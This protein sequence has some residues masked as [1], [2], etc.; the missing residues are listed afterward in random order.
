[1]E[2]TIAIVILSFLL[3]LAIIVIYLMAR[4]IRQQEKD[5]E[6]Q[7]KMLKAHND[8]NW[9]SINKIDEKIQAVK[10]EAQKKID[11]LNELLHNI[12]E[13]RND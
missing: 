3:I 12:S 4:F 1:M 9:A 13:E 7:M 11:R 8:A 2:K 10:E 6:E 5:F